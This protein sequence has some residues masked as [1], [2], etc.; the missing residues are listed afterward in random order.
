MNRLCSPSGW[1][2]SQFYS[3]Y[4]LCDFFFVVVVVVI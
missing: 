2:E 4:K 1:F 3:K